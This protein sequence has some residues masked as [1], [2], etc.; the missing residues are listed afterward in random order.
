MKSDTVNILRTAHV[1]LLV[2][3]LARSKEFYINMLGFVLTK[4]TS[5]QLYLRGV[6]ERVHHSIVLTKSAFAAVG[7]LSFRVESNQDLETLHKIYT[8]QGCVARFREAGEELGQGRALIVQD[9]LGFPIEYFADMDEAESYLQQYHL[10]QGAAVKRMDHF[11]IFVQNLIKASDLWLNKLAFRMSE[12]VETDEEPKTKSAIWTHRKPN[13]HD[14]AL[15]QGEGPR[16]H[17]I[18]F[19]MDD[20]YGI[21]RACD[22][23]ASAGM[24]A[25]IERGP[26]RHGISNAFFLYLR[27]PDGH[28]IELYT[29]D[30]LTTDPDLKPIRWSA[31]DPR[32]QTLWGHPTPESWWNEASRV[33]NISTNRVADLVP[34]ES[35]HPGHIK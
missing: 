35:I 22:I 34:A 3:D 27:D 15:M 1:E 13:V 8:S 25:A 10:H 16:V 9:P 4:E 23:L 26:G 18:G 17:H 24:H 33:V 6:E 14:L 32:R 28:R 20:V 31:T 7:H 5:T 29:G 30:Y 11:N 19:W 12:Y 21:I 2:T